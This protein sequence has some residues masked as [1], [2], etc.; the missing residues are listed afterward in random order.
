VVSGPTEFAM[1]VSIQMTAGQTV[2]TTASGTW[3]GG[4]AFTADGDPSTTV[5]GDN[6]PLSGA[7]LVAL[8][9][10]IGP[11]GSMNRSSRDLGSLLS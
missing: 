4:S 6:C 5:N 11:N 2:S 8:V 1:I 10:R 3:T 7:P 9:G